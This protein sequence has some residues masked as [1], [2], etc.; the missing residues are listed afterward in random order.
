MFAISCPVCNKLVVLALGTSGAL[1][2][3]APIQPLLGFLSVGLLLYALRAQLAGDPFARE[4]E[5]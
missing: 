1:T 4:L 2:Y 5:I 3:F